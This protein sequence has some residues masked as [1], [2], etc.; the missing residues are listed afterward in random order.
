MKQPF[1]N[2]VKK[3]VASACKAGNSTLKEL[4]STVQLKREATIVRAESVPM[5]FNKGESLRHDH[6]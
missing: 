4:T 5:H 3:E 1:Q 6:L 2:G